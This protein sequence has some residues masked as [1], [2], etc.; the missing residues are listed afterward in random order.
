MFKDYNHR[1]DLKNNKNTTSAN[2]TVPINV[3]VSTTIS[4]MSADID[5]V[6][7]PPERINKHSM[8][9]T[10]QLGTPQQT[11]TLNGELNNEKVRYFILF[12][13]KTDVIR[14]ALERSMPI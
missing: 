1:G 6:T 14:K 9:Q 5:L 13:T 7:K 8:E 3:E 10:Q 2:I 4:N 11:E 12:K